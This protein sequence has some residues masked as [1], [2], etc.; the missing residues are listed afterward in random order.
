[1][2]EM[3]VCSII[4]FSPTLPILLFLSSSSISIPHSLRERE[5]ETKRKFS[6]LKHPQTFYF[7]QYFQWHLDGLS[8]VQKSHNQMYQCKIKVM[9]TC[10]H[11]LEQCHHRVN[12]T[13]LSINPHR[14]LIII[15]N[16][17]YI[18][19]KTCLNTSQL[20]MWEDGQK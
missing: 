18:L 5:T 15:Q 20:S 10:H 1:M 12:S 17:E 2:E 6:H 13:Y 16:R 19:R 9:Q 4:S 14:N 11:S 7:S 8:S 3:T